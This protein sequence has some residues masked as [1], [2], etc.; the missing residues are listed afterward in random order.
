[1]TSRR[2]QSWVEA[3]RLRAHRPSGG[4]IASLLAVVERDLGDAG[5]TAISLDRRFAT[6]YAAALQL[7]TV[8][9]AA[10]GYRVSAQRG[11]HVITMQALPELIGE[12]GRQLAA[13]FDS[14]RVLRNR[15]DYDHVGA[16]SGRDVEELLSQTASFRQLVLEWLAGAHPEL[17][18]K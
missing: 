6:A 12:Q 13:Y 2:L 8:V 18:P 17:L 9:L 7:A 1:V 11:H 16:V 4:E 14:C 10:S 15:S 3:G 5:V